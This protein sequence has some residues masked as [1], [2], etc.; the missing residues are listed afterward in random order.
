MSYSY[1]ASGNRTARTVAVGGQELSG[2]GTQEDVRYCAHSPKGGTSVGN[3]DVPARH[4]VKERTAP[5]TEGPEPT[6][7]GIPP[8]RKKQ[9]GWLAEHHYPHL[10]D[11]HKPHPYWTASGPTATH[12]PPS[13]R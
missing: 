4:G 12:R 8:N 9:T 6:K 7:D 13:A 3:A 5:S 11:A 2:V 10:A 1:D